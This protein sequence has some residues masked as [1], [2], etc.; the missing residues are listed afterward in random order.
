M[1]RRGMLD[2]NDYFKIIGDLGAL[3]FIQEAER[4]ADA[5]LNG[6]P[7]GKWGV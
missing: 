3:A 7:V 4:R 5:V 6:G 1:A 2:I